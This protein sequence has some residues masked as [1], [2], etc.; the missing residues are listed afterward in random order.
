MSSRY[1][2]TLQAPVSSPHNKIETTIADYERDVS[3]ILSYRLRKNSLRIREI[4]VDERGFMVINLSDDPNHLAE[5]A[6]SFEELE[7]ELSAVIERGP[8]GTF[9]SGNRAI[10][11]DRPEYDAVF[12]SETASCPVCEE[13]VAP[14]SELEE[15]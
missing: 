10:K 12:G 14:A 11:Y 8:G 13:Q 1:R 3:P 4:C 7:Q 15:A 6:S 2:E 5:T 9:F